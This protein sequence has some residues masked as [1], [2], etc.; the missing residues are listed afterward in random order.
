MP[1]LRPIQNAQ[2]R[3][4]VMRSIL[5]GA[6]GSAHVPKILQMF[7]RHKRHKIRRK[8]V[9]S[10][11]KR[12][13]EAEVIQ[14]PRRRVRPRAPDYPYRREEL[15]DYQTVV[16]WLRLAD[17]LLGSAGSDSDDYEDRDHRKRVN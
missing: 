8:A 11:F 9:Y 1:Y 3:P 6:S 7:R 16:R 15:P 4:I 2:Y 10:A 14:L 12:V 5:H 13:L 17:E